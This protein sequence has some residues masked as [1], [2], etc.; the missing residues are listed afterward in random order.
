MLAIIQI[1]ALPVATGVAWVGGLR[2]PESSGSGNRIEELPGIRVHG[3]TQISRVPIPS[4]ARSLPLPV[5]RAMPVAVR[6]WDCSGK[7]RGRN[8]G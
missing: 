2:Q 3:L 8:P 6:G 5:R 4:A 7:R 1:N